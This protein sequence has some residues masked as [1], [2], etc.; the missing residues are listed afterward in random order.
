MCSW[1]SKFQKNTNINEK[2]VARLT[3][4][5]TVIKAFEVSSILL[6]AG[7]DKKIA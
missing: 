2:A 5:L 7:D 4:S 3:S 1:P 6:E